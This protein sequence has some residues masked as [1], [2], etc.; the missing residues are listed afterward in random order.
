MLKSK[1]FTNSSEV[2]TTIYLLSE[3]TCDIAVLN[4]EKCDILY[5]FGSRAWEYERKTKALGTGAMKSVLVGD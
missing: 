2:D 1:I 3:L 4:S 5:D